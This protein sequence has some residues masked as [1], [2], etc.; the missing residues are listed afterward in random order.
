[1]IP[2][3]T[4]PSNWNAFGIF[5]LTHMASSWISAKQSRIT[6][7][8]RS[9][10]AMRLPDN[11]YILLY[12]Y[13]HTLTAVV[14]W[15]HWHFYRQF[16]QVFLFFPQKC[17]VEHFALTSENQPSYFT[18]SHFCFKLVFYLIVPQFNTKTCCINTKIRTS[19]HMLFHWEANISAL[20]TTD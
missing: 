4:I 8:T 17:F 7:T 6:V 14:I 2:R 5:P 10:E 9:L 18:E 16:D 20:T 15:R 3:V 19:S 11:K 12:K 13:T 1:M